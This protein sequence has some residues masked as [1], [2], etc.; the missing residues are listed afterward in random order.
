MNRFVMS[1]LTVTLVAGSIPAEDAIW[2]KNVYAEESVS[3]E[4]PAPTETPVP[5]EVP[6]PT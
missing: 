5:T 3:M 4:A 6:A 2:I 1:T